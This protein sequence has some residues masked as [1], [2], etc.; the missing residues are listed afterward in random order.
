MFD[1]GFGGFGSGFDDGLTL[2][3]SGR[4]DDAFGGAADGGFTRSFITGGEDLNHL[5]GTDANA[6][7]WGASRRLDLLGELGRARCGE[8]EFGRPRRVLDGPRGRRE[9]VSLALDQVRAVRPAWT[10]RLILG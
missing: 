4:F 6:E 8:L 2:S 10:G 5:M 1:D 9:R 3:G 7:V